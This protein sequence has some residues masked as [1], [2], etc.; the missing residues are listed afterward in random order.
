ML[1]KQII[2]GILGGATGCVLTANMVEV[3]PKFEFNQPMFEVIG[4]Y[5]NCEIVRF[6]SGDD[7]DHFLDCPDKIV[8]QP[9]GDWNPGR[10][11]T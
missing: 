5:D 1:I 11:K 9:Y 4:T 3:E 2:L 7:I 6:T 8:H 10:I